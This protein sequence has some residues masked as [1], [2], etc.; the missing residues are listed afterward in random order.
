MIKR[1][2]TYKDGSIKLEYPRIFSTKPLVKSNI[3]LY[4]IKSE[5]GRIMD[6]YSN[7][8]KEEILNWANGQSAYHN[9][10]FYNQVDETETMELAGMI[11]KEIEIDKKG[12]NKKYES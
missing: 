11:D 7:T 10:F 4:Q 5:D 6:I 3:K 1:P 9:G 8:T 2:D 12:D